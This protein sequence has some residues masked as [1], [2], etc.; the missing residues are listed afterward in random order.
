[1]PIAHNILTYIHT[2][3]MYIYMIIYV[4]YR[5]NKTYTT[6]QVWIEYEAQTWLYN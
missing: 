2:V 5:I 6:T 4:A 1:M 3:H